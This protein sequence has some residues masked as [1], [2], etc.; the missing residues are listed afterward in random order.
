MRNTRLPAEER[1]PEI[2]S[3]FK[4]R[5]SRQLAI[6]Q[7]EAHWRLAAAQLLIRC[8]PPDALAPIRS[9]LYKWAGF[10]GIGY[11]AKENWITRLR[12]T[13][14]I[15]ASKT[16]KRRPIVSTGCSLALPAATSSRSMSCRV[17]AAECGLRASPSMAAWSRTTRRYLN[18]CCRKRPPGVCA[19]APSSCCSM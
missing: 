8:L 12:P 17:I 11:I 14:V 2:T 18:V 16:M 10:K 4:R 9:A 5:M 7:T 1:E 6:L 3:K 13:I 15:C 19:C